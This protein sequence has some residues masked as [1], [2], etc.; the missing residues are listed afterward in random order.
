MAVHVP[1]SLFGHC[2]LRLWMITSVT[3]SLSG[4]DLRRADR[5]PADARRLATS[6]RWPAI[7][8]AVFAGA[9]DPRD[10]GL[11]PLH[12]ERPVRPDDRRAVPGRDRLPSVR[13][14]PL[15][16]RARR[17]GIARAA[18]GVAVPRALRDLGVARDPVDA[19]GSIYGGLALIPLLWFGV[20]TITNDRPFVSGQLALLSPRELHQNK[21]IG[22]LHRFTALTYLPMQLMALV[23]IGLAWLRRNWTVLI[24]GR[25]RGRVDRRRDR[26]RP[27]RL[28]GRPALPVR[29][30]RR[31]DRARRR[32]R[33]GWLLQEA[34]RTRAPRAALGGRRARRCCSS[35][36]LVPGALARLPHGA[37]GPQARARPHD[38][39]RP[40]PGR[41]STT[42]AATQHILACG[43]PV[44]TVEYVSILAY[45]TKLNDGK[46]GHRPQFEL[47]QKYPIVMFTPLHSGW[48]VVPVA[49]GGGKVARVREPERRA[50]STPARHPDGVLVPQR[51]T[52]GRSA[53]T[54]QGTTS[55]LRRPRPRRRRPAARGAARSQPWTLRGV[56]ARSTRGGRPA[57]ASLSLSAV[58]VAA[59]ADAARLRS[60]RL[61][62]VG[63]SDA[64]AVA[65]HERGAVVEAAAVPVHGPVRAVRPLPGV[66]VDDRV[67]RGLAER[68]SCSRGGSPTG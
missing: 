27:A 51:R 63:P 49:H 37:P 57:S 11:L 56:H 5:L 36:A 17:A 26:V 8:A 50:G 67:A 58:I 45:F 6:S 52:T 35:S 31:D 55:R 48:S 22:T 18:R 47:Q 3:I 41:R 25:G 40:A 19:R 30:G 12:P 53:V 39:D 44:T 14:P 10:P 32:S 4:S 29:A 60:L 54:T 64:D 43:E 38:G 66:A 13:P 65:R 21:I 2:A 9:R 68:A 24:L 20:P 46:I 62:R 15:G 61:A 23:A 7:A 28:A 42:S 34:P 16:V 1:Y 33:V 59:G